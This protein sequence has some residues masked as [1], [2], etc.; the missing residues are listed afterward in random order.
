MSDLFI[1][2]YVFTLSTL[3][4]QSFGFKA[5]EPTYVSPQAQAAALATGF[6]T[7]ADAPAPIEAPA[8]DP[9]P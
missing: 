2:V 3:A 5:G 9:A 6:I 1:S 7:S 8:E 4:G